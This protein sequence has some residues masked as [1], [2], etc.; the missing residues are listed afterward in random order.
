MCVCVGT[1]G[2]HRRQIVSKEMTVIMFKEMQV[3]KYHILYLCYTPW[4]FK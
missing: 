4:V 2:G 3:L 1:H